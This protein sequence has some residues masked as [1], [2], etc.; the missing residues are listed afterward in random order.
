MFDMKLRNKI[1][2][3]VA[4]LGAINFFVNA[5]NDSSNGERLYEINKQYSTLTTKINALEEIKKD[6][7]GI[8]KVDGVLEYICEKQIT[9]DS[10]EKEEESCQKKSA[11]CLRRALVF[12]YFTD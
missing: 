1:M 8:M 5:L 10:L 3:G 4:T 9:A 11:K 7:P 2:L 12:G 6:V